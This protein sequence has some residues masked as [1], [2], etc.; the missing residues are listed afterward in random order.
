MPAVTT[1]LPLPVNHVF[2]DFENVH[3]IDLAVIASEADG[4]FTIAMERGVYFNIKKRAFPSFSRLHEF[5][6]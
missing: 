3:E 1:D 2:V 6:T 5:F 4:G